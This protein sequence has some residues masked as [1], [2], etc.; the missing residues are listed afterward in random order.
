[1]EY[2]RW[3]EIKSE[4]ATYQAESNKIK[5]ELAQYTQQSELE[6]KKLIDKF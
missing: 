1:M 5:V 6:L 4:R 3:I 2:I